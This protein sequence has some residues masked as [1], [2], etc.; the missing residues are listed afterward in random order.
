MLG[1]VKARRVLLAL[2]GQGRL[3]VPYR[4]QAQEGLHAGSQETIH[5][6]HIC[7]L[8]LGPLSL[9]PPETFPPWGSG[10]E[11]FQTSWLRVMRT[12]LRANVGVVF[13]LLVLRASVFHLDHQVPRWAPTLVSSVFPTESELHTQCLLDV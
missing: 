11:F 9:I 12:L 4:G 10:G 3:S 5:S 13:S 8:L 1:S 7:R 2:C 6:S